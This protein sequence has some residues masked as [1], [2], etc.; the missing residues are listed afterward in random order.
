M[1]KMLRAAAA[2]QADYTGLIGRIAGLLE[3]ARRATVRVTNALLTATYWEV[4]R[5][6]VEFE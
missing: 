2:L 6:I 1:A 3:Q 5:Q 4:G